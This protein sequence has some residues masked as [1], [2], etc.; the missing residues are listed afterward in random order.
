MRRLAVIGAG[1]VGLTTATCLAELGNEVVCIDV[2]RDKIA[3]LR[4]GHVPV[5][6]PGLL[7]MVQHNQHDGRLTFSDEPGQ[8]LRGREMIFIAVGTPLHENGQLDLSAIEAAAR[9]IAGSLDG[10]VI[11]VNK[12]T[13]PVQTADLVAA[14]I[15]RAKPSTH[16]VTV[17]SNPEF[18]RE[19]SAIADFMHPDR[20]VIGVS[21]GAAESELRD[22]YAPLEAPVLVTDPRTA[23]MIKLTSNAFLATKVSFINEIANICEQVGADVKEV[24]LGAGS[25]RRIGATFMNPGLGFGGSCFPKDVLALVQMAEVSKVEPRLLRGT[26]EVNRSQIDRMLRRLETLLDGL[27][28]RHVAVFGLSFKPGT[29]DVRESPALALVRALLRADAIVSAHDPVAISNAHRELGD[30]VRYSDSQYDAAKDAHALVI[31][32]DW[33]EYKQLD[34][35]IL[36]SVM[37]GRVILDARNIYDPKKIAAEG[38]IYSG[39]GR[40]APYHAASVD[41]QGRARRKAQ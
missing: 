40:S 36:R 24:V 15:E 17:V 20:I 23:E 34:F 9:D 22:L 31:A 21:D 1:Y 10:P 7:E 2:D 30:A 4:A 6:E 29:D 5:Y 28:G 38:F 3:A 35:G 33:N 16:K 8:A 39:V 14:F 37:A 41:A 25:D 32:T 26:L 27:R 18:L 19:G 13:V 12:S 11:V